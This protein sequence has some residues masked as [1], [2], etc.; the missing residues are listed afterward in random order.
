M[1]KPK[2]KKHFR[3]KKTPLATSLSLILGSAATAAVLPNAAQAQVGSSADDLEVIVVRGIRGSLGRSMD[4]KRQSTGVV[5]AITAED[6][7]KFPDG[8][9]AESLQRVTG[10]SIDR[11]NGE[12]FQV[13]SRGFGPHFN[14]VTLNGRVMPVAQLNEAGGLNTSR[15]FDMSNI[16]SEGVSGVTV[17]KSGQANI[18]SGGIGATID[19]QTRKPFQSDGF[20]YSVGIKALSDTTNRIGS[21]LTPEASGFASWSDDTWGVSASVSIQ[22]RDNGRTGAYVNGWNDYSY[23]WEGNGSIPNGFTDDLAVNDAPA[24]GTQVNFANGL[25]YTHIDYERER[26]NA[27]IA[28]QFRPSD[29]MLATLDYT[30]AM[31]GLEGNRNELSF[32]YGGGAFPTSAVQFTESNGVATPLYWLQENVPNGYQPRDVNFGLQ[33]ASLENKLK[34][35]GL[36]LEWDLNDEMVLSFDYHDSE[37]TALPGGNGPGNFYNVGI[38]AQGVSVQG[39]DNSGPLPLLVG[40]WGQRSEDHDDDESTPE[41]PVNGDVDGAIDKGDLS[42]TVRQI[43]YDRTVSDL[44]Q[45]RVDLE[46]DVSEEATIDFGVESRSMEHSTRSSFD[47]TVLEGNWGASNPGD[48]P[49]DMVDALNFHALFDGYSSEMSPGAR[50]YFSQHYGGEAMQG[51]FETFGAVSYIGKAD[52]LGALLSSNAN[53][54]WVPNPVDGTNRLIA[55]DIT[56]VYGQ[57][58]LTG[59]TGGYTYQILAGVRYEETEVTSTAQIPEPVIVWNGDNDFQVLGGDA[60]TAPLV[61]R[62]AEYDHVLPSFGLAVDITEDIVARVAWGTTIA[63]ANYASLQHGVSGIGGPIG[64]PTALDGMNGGATNG[65][66]GLLPVESDNLDLSVEWYYADSSYFAIGWFDKRV[67]NFIGTE[68]VETVADSTRDP[69]NGPRVRAAI[70]ELEERGIDVTQQSLFSMVAALDNGMGGCIDE[71]M[72]MLCGSGADMVGD[73]LGSDGT[74]LYEGADGWENNVDIVALPED[75]LSILDASTPVNANGA[76]ISGWEIASQHFFG[77]TGF[78]V[79]ANLTLVDGS[80]NFDVADTSGAPQFALAGLG[81]SA[82]LVLIYE[83]DRIQARLAFNWRDSFLD[84]PNVGG[85]EPQFTESYQQVDFSVGYDLADNWQ[86]VLEGINVTEEDI[87]RYGRSEAQFRNLEI[88]GARYAL[89]TRYVF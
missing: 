45:F 33:G 77:D 85:N 66:V 3:F 79:Q 14:Q 55:E 80:V 41:V 86:I 6:I 13:T 88:L 76:S 22:N 58:N 89:S 50:A 62:T 35:L 63:R 84:A 39:I 5:D 31:Q 9:L 34:S 51:N 73:G 12:G 21:S 37:A 68:E 18:T 23:Q 75:P 49:P 2:P 30:Y 15:S 69:T 60:E 42:S 71:K 87:R 74:T 46:W 72:L 28:V 19:L 27:Q 43:W 47:Q 38:G 52:P 8:N 64:G 17:Y 32:W 24:M 82:N 26:Q 65:N 44:N 10:L 67:P 70:A 56:S 57:I 48:I 54:D 83:K 29:G 78:G 16:A 25:R 53:L 59:E 7:G 20:T 1:P 61:K 40:V 4:I 11:R 36:N 81:D